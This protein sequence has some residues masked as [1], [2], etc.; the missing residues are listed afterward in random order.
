[1]ITVLSVND[2]RQLSFSDSN[3]LLMQGS[4][5]DPVN[6]S[7]LYNSIGEQNISLFSFAPENFS[8][9]VSM[10]NLTLRYTGSTE[11]LSSPFLVKSGT[12]MLLSFS[13]DSKVKSWAIVAMTSNY[14]AAIALITLG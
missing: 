6:M 8:Y 11:I 12:P 5:K 3:P 10:E 9:E 1:M 2:S 13:A 4:Y 14:D 7:F